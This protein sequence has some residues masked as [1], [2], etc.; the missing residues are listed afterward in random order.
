MS[1]ELQLQDI[2]DQ[3]FDVEE[4]LPRVFKIRNFISTDEVAELLDELTT[5]DED[6]WNYRYLA[7]M[8]KS[9]FSKFGRDDIENLVAEG[10]LEV[11]STWADKNVAIANQQMV[12]ELH[13]RASRIFQTIDGLEVAG[14][15]VAQRMYDGSELKAH[16]DQYSDK[17]VEY[18]AV[19]YLNDDYVAGELFFTNF[20]GTIRPE[21]GSLLIFPGTTSHEHGVHFVKEGPVRY[22][23]P[24][25]VRSQHPDGSMAGWANFG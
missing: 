17:L 13:R 23:L 8:R 19:L 6:T 12:D 18:A 15:V 24:T 7:E 4:I 16:H 10:L 5:Y 25:F 20:E 22:V 9:S 14:F 2:V 11:T 1:R 21:P 3:G